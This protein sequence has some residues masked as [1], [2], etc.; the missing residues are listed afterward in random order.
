MFE[1][2][3]NYLLDSACIRIHSFKTK[4]RKQAFVRGIRHGVIISQ[5]IYFP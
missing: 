1:E 3:V 5:H 2:C 4:R